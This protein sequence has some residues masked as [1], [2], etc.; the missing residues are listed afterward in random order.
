MYS[1]MVLI[2][3]LALPRH[4]TIIT[5]GFIV[6]KLPNSLIG[7]RVSLTMAYFDAVLLPTQ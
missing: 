6:V 4:M 5:Y 2:I 7:K 1:K 3:G